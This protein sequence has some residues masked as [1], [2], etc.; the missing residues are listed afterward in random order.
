MGSGGGLSGLGC[1]PCMGILHQLMRS[2]LKL[3]IFE[4]LVNWIDIN[5]RTC[6]KQDPDGAPRR[7]SEN[8]P[9]GFKTVRPIIVVVV[10]TGRAT[11]AAACNDAPF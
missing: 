3:I 5:G 9:T 10:E 7:G 1:C 8:G 4:S 2:S 6:A 11:P